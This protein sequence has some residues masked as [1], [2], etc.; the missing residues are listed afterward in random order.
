MINTKTLST[1]SAFLIFSAVEEIREP[2]ENDFLFSKNYE[3]SIEKFWKNI[4]MYHFYKKSLLEYVNEK[5]DEYNKYRMFLR[6]DCIKDFKLPNLKVKSTK[7]VTLQYYKIL[8]ATNK[9]L[10]YKKRLDKKIENIKKKII[11]YVI[12]EAIKNANS[13]KD[14]IILSNTDYIPKWYY[15]EV[16]KKASKK[17]NGTIIG[18]SD[19]IFSGYRCVA[20][21]P[22]KVN[23]NKLAKKW[24]P[25]NVLDTVCIYVPHNY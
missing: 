18:I 13:P 24:T 15:N 6:K 22:E 19:I 10:R 8:F 4:A 12:K 23:L 14:V 1:K 16:E 11:L 7:F 3:K 17:D 20:F 9:V 5:V 21:V 25:Y 2:R